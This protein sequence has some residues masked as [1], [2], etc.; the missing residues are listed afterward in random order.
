MFGRNRRATDDDNQALVGAGRTWNSKNPPADCAARP[1]LLLLVFLAARENMANI[2]ALGLRRYPLDH[3]A[4]VSALAD[5]K[6]W[7][8]N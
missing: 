6:L 3:C 7:T 8:A 5:A 1:L 2:M 4:I